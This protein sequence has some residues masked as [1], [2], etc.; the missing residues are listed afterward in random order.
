MQ[1][2]WLPGCCL[3]SS[4]ASLGSSQ[5]LCNARS[6]A[7]ELHATL[8]RASGWRC[9]WRELQTKQETSPATLF[10][11]PFSFADGVADP[12]ELGAALE[13]APNFLVLESAGFLVED[14]LLTSLTA[15]LPEPVFP[16]FFLAFFL[17]FFGWVL[18]PPGP[19]PGKDTRNAGFIG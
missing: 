15:G 7:N 11:L 8:T 19:V 9:F 17:F 5:P 2:G 10:W 1:N 18:S 6:K 3:I 16:S 13:P 12:L 4:F 14:A